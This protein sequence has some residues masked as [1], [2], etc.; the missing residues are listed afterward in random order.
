MPDSVNNLSPREP[1]E[2]ASPR[3]SR[4]YAKACLGASV[5]FVTVLAL[6]GLMS[7]ILPKPTVS[8]YEKREL[9]PFPAL[10]AKALWSGRWT[11]DFDAYYADTFPGRDAFIAATAVLD[12]WKGLRGKDD[13]RIY[14]QGQGQTQPSSSQAPSQAPSSSGPALEPDP[15]N[16]GSGSSAPESASSQSQSEAPPEVPDGY[17]TEGYCIVGDRGVTLF[18]GY[19]PVAEQYAGILT[20][21][22]DRLGDS[23]RVFNIVVPCSGEFYLPPQYQSL[24]NSQKDNIQFLYSK[25][26]ESVTPVDAY[27]PIAAHTGEYLY[28]RTDHH[29]TALGAYYAYQA[30]CEAAGLDC[31]EPGDFEVR[32][33]PDFLGT[34]YSATRDSQLGANPDHVDYYITAPNATAQL[35]LKGSTEPLEVFPWCEFSS[36]ANSYGVFIWA[37][38][39]LFIMHNP[40]QPNGKKALVMKESYGNAFAPWLM[41]NYETVYVIDYR[42]YEESV[43]DFVLENGIDDVI[44]IN[45]SFAANTSY[46]ADRIDYLCN[47]S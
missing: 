8:E 14:N 28:F 43:Y 37:D 16:E 26:G 29:W 32:T 35:F 44:F 25:L 20:N 7:L 18:G 30:Y 4:L 38:N 33:I 5:F 36:G 24:S 11:K 21:F 23:A 9:A 41:C 1:G 47:R 45:N 10:S 17:L 27:T 3:T 46:H 39:P 6:V 13:I 31:P 19:R 2:E 12:D 22:A 34:V 15:G 42:H 40:D